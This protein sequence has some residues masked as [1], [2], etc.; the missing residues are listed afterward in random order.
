MD[1]VHQ[2]ASFFKKVVFMYLAQLG[3]HQFDGSLASQV[4]MLA[5]VNLGESSL[6]QARD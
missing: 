3:V 6:A 5:K 1:Q 4:D 2:E